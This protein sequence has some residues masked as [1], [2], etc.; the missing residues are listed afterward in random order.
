MKKKLLAVALCVCTVF[1]VAGCK[2]K[3]KD[4]KTETKYELGQYKGIEVD[5]SLKTVEK[6][7]WLM[8]I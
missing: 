5:S 8:F 1:S 3:D 4:K 2:E 7:V 6:V